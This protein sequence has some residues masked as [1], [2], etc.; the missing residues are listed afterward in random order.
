M[1]A[2]LSIRELRHRRGGRLV[3][4]VDELELGP[5]ERLAVLGPNG[6]GKTT[7][8]RLIAA[9]DTPSAGIVA[10]DGVPTAEADAE[11]RRRVGYATQRAGLLS[12]TVARNV[13]L[14]LRWRGVGRAERRAAALAALGRLGVAHLAERPAFAL[15][16][17]EAQRV[18]LARALAV[19]PSVLLLDEPAAGLDAPGRQSFLDDLEAAL[20]DRATTVVHVSHRAEEALR[21]A[22]RV[23]V[24]VAGAVDQLGAPGDVVRRPA[25]AIAARLVGYDNVIP[26]E[27]DRH[28]QV[29]IAGE[30][31]GLREARSPGPVTVAAWGAAVQ[32]MPS[33]SAGLQATVERVSPGA[34]RWDVVL[35]GPAPL[36][37]HLPLDH[38]LPRP[39]DRVG[40]R[41]DAALATLISEA[42]AERGAPSYPRCP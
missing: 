23:A 30:P 10:L 36:R 14:P 1:G 31:C 18:S 3:L 40:V 21:I 22:D 39:G 15:S 41:L 37:A 13:E 25:T 24:L 17:G 33:K 34:G 16:G 6:A 2:S 28:G 9:L 7:L 19:D 4:S 8:L 35:A 20:S 29:L 12:T 27:I 11:F 38:A 26:A 5:G 32:L 42:P